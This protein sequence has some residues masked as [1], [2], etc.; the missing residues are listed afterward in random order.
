MKKNCSILLNI[1]VIKSN[2]KGR[3]LARGQG[4]ARRKGPDRMIWIQMEWNGVMEKVK[5]N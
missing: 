3:V 2:K 1:P 4:Q 5:C